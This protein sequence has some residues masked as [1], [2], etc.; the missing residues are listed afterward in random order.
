MGNCFSCLRSKSS[1]RPVADSSDNENLDNVPDKRVE[2][3]DSNDLNPPVMAMSNGAHNA[4][5]LGS[6]GS[7]N[8]GS[9]RS[10]FTCTR[11]TSTL[12]KTNMRLNNFSTKSFQ[13]RVQKLFDMYKDAVEDLIL[14][15]GIERLCSDL[16]MSPEEFRILI[17]A[18]K[19]DAHQMCRFTRA[20][21]LN[22]CHALQVDSVSLMKNKLSDVA[23]DLNYNTE[24]FK[25]LY[26]FTF[27]FGL[28]NAVGQ[29]ILPVDTAI[30]LWKLIFNIRE[31]DILERWLNFLESQDNI[32]GIPKDTWNMFL[33]FA[34]SVS[35]GD[36]SNYDDTEA[37]PSVFD[38]FVEYENDQANQNISEKGIGKKH[39]SVL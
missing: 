30:V 36:L 8:C 15:D 10:S 5:V 34:E 16:Q 22:G 39:G 1:S 13:T 26:R 11:L 17:L 12:N 4:P 6:V 19:C 29:R 33:N 2:G 14:I 32:R 23:N 18:W 38:D 24:E 3:L 27:K 21:F 28:D 20:E 7:D 31:P 37:W 35:N 25:S 9:L